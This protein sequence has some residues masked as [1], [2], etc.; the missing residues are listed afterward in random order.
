[1]R[2]SVLYGVLATIISISTYAQ[3][4]ST[5]PASLSTV[6]SNDAFLH[7]HPLSTSDDFLDFREETIYFVF[8]DRFSDGDVS[9]NEGNDSSTYDPDNL[10]KYNGGDIR[11]LINKMPYL[12][13]LGITAIWITPPVD[14]ADF[15]SGSTASYHG[16]WGKDYFRVDEHFGTEDDLRELAAL[17]HSPEYD[18][19]LVLDF[20]PN[21]S[22]ANDENEFGLLL[23][24]GVFQTDYST[25]VS[26]GTNWY[27]HNGGITDWENEDQVRNY[28]LFNLSDFNQDNLDTYNYLMDATK[29]WIDVGFDAIRIDA[30]KH[31]DKS[32]IQSWTS[33]IYDYASSIGREGF[34]FFGEWFGASAW[35]TTG[36]DGQAIDYANTSGSALLDFGF[37]NILQRV[38]TGRHANDMT[39]INAYLEDRENVFTSDEW[40]VVFMDN[41]DAARIS[42]VLRSSSANFGPANNEVGG[43]MSVAE[44][45]SRLNL[46][47]VITMTVRGIP[48]IY[49]GTEQYAANFEVND[50]GQIGSDPY[51]R[52]MMP[53]FDISTNEAAKIIKALATLRKS[54]PAIQ[55]GSYTQRWINADILVYEREFEG[56]VVT[57]AVNRG[58]TASIDVV[59][60][61]IADGTYTSLVGT[62]TVTVTGGSATLSLDTDE[63]IV[64]HQPALTQTTVT[65][66]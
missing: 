62:D 15:L 28:N 8:L 19:K 21:H 22:N 7:T 17:A 42:T 23:R 30:I 1:M 66:Q 24:D 20:A 2:R 29:H 58:E 64:L 41:H 38:L 45:Q 10:Q 11:G 4:D 54:S 50:F 43:A 40:Q 16:Y 12:K 13:E 46:G 56:E 61:A 31:M 39:S 34:Y 27:H 35:T 47:L 9:N 60:L 63:A 51:N 37:K 65:P 49:Y 3:P 52:E 36:L 44:A 55:E 14:N 18:M 32:F 5:P 26:S 48:A 6:E 25:D 53:S 33:E 59:G 57:V